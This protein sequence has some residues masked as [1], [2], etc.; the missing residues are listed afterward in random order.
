MGGA[1][2]SG[3]GL[4][5]KGEVREKLTLNRSHK[6]SKW[7]H[8][9]SHSRRGVQCIMVLLCTQ[10]WSALELIVRCARAYSHRAAKQLC[11]S[12]P[13]VRS[14]A[15]LCLGSSPVVPVSNAKNRRDP[16]N[17]QIPHLYL[18]QGF[19][20]RASI[21]D[22][23]P[24]TKFHP[25]GPTI[26]R[27]PVETPKWLWKGSQIL[28]RASQGEAGVWSRKAIPSVLAQRFWAECAVMKC[29]CLFLVNAS[30]VV[31]IIAQL[32]QF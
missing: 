26:R 9:R 21:F 20:C 1:I 27:C 13:G 16:S 30:T 17:R 3:G 11:L 4:W 31:W 28:S 19:G 5:C 10:G 18:A 12:L 24:W 22:I 8:A 6:A 25:L 2:S 7:V 14:S 29:L 23:W 32:L 15:S